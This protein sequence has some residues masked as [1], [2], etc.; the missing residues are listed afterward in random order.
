MQ[1]GWRRWSGLPHCLSCT[2]SSSIQHRL[3]SQCC[4]LYCC[5]FPPNELGP[6][7]VAMATMYAH[8]GHNKWVGAGAQGGDF[9]AGDGTGGESIYGDTFADENFRLKHDGP[10]VLSMANAG[11]GTNGSQFFLC[12]VPCPWLDGKHGAPPSLAPFRPGSAGSPPPSSHGAPL[13]PRPGEHPVSRRAS[14]RLPPRCSRQLALGPPQDWPTGTQLPVDTPDRA[15]APFLVRAP[16]QRTRLQS[17]FGP[18][19]A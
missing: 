6:S 17:Q 11:P 3:F 2:G 12:T 19:H 16:V 10:G 9:T 13:P 5:S 15:S 18:G 4:R 1:L 7:T 8:P 14:R